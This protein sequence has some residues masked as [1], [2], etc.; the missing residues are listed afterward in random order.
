M[1]YAVR[2]DT[3]RVAAAAAELA[4]VHD[5]LE[6]AGG[7]LAQA[8]R[9]AA[10]AAGNGVLAAT[11]EAAAGQWQGG[12]VHVALHGRDLARATLEAA[13]LYRTA[14]LLAT[15]AFRLPVPGGAP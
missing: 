4:A 8:L 10:G 14:E 3:D 1:G 13:E 2:V 11:A 9:A 5:D 6:R 7:A 15:R 12:M